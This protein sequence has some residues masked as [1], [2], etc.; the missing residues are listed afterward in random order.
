MFK[1]KDYDYGRSKRLSFC[2]TGYSGVAVH[3]DSP[4]IEVGMF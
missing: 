2:V 4:C 1:W 3:V